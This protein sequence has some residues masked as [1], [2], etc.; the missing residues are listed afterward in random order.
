MDGRES[1]SMPFRYEREMLEPATEW[2][3]GQGLLV[4]KE[5]PT[6]WGICDLV[7][8]SLNKTRVRQRLKLRQRQPIRSQLRVHLLSL[9]P[10]E[11]E[12]GTIDV[13]RL[14]EHFDPYIDR[15]RIEVELARLL[16]DRFIEERGEGTYFKRN[17]WMPLHKRLVAVELKL[18]RIDDAL[19]Q[20]I[21]NLGFADESYVALPT[22]VA[23]RLLNSK[24]KAD[25]AE[26]GIGVLALENARCTMILRARKRR[27]SPERTTQ[28]Y[29]VE[30][31]WLPHVKGSEA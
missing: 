27:P 17:G 21:N 11:K 28:T 24:R 5:F 3:R 29:S 30:R 19:H 25:F 7:G 18:T 31:F 9:I 20:A 14:H 12:G 2:L 22:D 10:D 23:A 4:K 1:M 15:D 26:K 8:C 16:R 13:D 6:P